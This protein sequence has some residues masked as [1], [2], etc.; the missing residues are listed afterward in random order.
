MVLGLCG[1]LSAQIE[2]LEVEVHSGLGRSATAALLGKAPEKGPRA[3]GTATIGDGVLQ[4]QGGRRV[5][6]SSRGFELALDGGGTLG[7]DGQ[8]RICAG[9]KALTKRVRGWVRLCLVDGLELRLRTG[10]LKKGPRDMVAVLGKRTFRLFRE[11]E[12]RE[13][14]KKRFAGFSFYLSG[15][16][17]RVVSLVGMGPLVLE[18]P[19]AVRGGD[20]RVRVHLLADLLRKAGSVLREKTPRNSAQ[21]PRAFSQAIFLERVV[22][23]LFPPE[24]PKRERLVAVPEF[25]LS[26]PFEGGISLQIRAGHGGRTDQLVLGLRLEPSA[27]VTVEYRVLARG[28]TVQ[29]VLPE[30]LQQRSRTFG[31]RPLV[32]GAASLLPWT[33]YLAHPAQR[34]L[35]LRALRPFFRGRRAIPVSASS[36][37]KKGS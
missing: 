17:D 34:Q 15:S 31:P 14:K 24:K 2:G 28:F 22:T 7:L 21:F 8:G 5:S 13:E 27:P 37:K 12:R 36:K 9:T 33:P 11:R 25:G 16:E 29:R 19:V 1:G 32:E 3:T 30:K 4:F 18:R 6:F 23:Q 20:K 26:L 35:S 10:N